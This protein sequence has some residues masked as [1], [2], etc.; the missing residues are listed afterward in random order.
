MYDHVLD[1]CGDV[2]VRRSVVSRAI[3]GCTPTISDR[4]SRKEEEGY[5]EDT[6][7]SVVYKFSGQSND[8]LQTIH[9]EIQ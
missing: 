3:G 6:V 9:I 7:A 1:L 8:C 4:I 5:R 2:L